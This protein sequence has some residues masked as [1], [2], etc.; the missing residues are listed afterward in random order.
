MLKHHLSLLYKISCS[1][2][3]KSKKKNLI[4]AVE[5][6]VA[7]ASSKKKSLFLLD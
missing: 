3:L 2:F 4:K 6:A 5:V 1:L 7:V